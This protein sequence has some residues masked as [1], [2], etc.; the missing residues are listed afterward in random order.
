MQNPLDNQRC[1]EVR[2]PV[3]LGAILACTGIWGLLA[4]CSDSASA[5]PSG[6]TAVSA[7][8]KEVAATP[9]PVLDAYEAVR[10]HLAADQLNEAV[11]ASGTIAKN[12]SAAVTS[13]GAAPTAALEA[14]EAAA[15]SMSEMQGKNARDVRKQFGE[16]SQAL[17]HWLSTTPELAQGRYA[18]ECPMAQGYKKWVQ[19]TPAMANPYMGKRMLKCGS[20]TTITP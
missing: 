9:H 19:V 14:I 17:V 7:N 1:F 2:A 4:A 18:F 12:A 11:S 10:A 16:L 3:R 13:A 15:K 8:A 20:T 6:T 5:N